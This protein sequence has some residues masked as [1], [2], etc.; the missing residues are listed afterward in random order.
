[1]TLLARRPSQSHS[2]LS[3]RATRGWDDHVRSQPLSLL[4][5]LRGRHQVMLPRS[6]QTAAPAAAHTRYSH[7]IVEMLEMVHDSSTM[8]IST[9][10]PAG[11]TTT[12][13]T[14]TDTPALA[15]STSASPSG[16]AT[17]TSPPT[18]PRRSTS[19]ATLNRTI[20]SSLRSMSDTALA[21]S[22]RDLPRAIGDAV[23][24]S[25]AYG[26]LYVGGGMPMCAHTGGATAVNM[27]WG[28]GS[29]MASRARSPSVVSLSSASDGN[30][31]G[32]GGRATTTGRRRSGGLREAMSR[33]RSASG[34]MES[35]RVNTHA[36]SAAAQ[37][38][39]SSLAVQG[40]EVSAD[41]RRAGD[42]DPDDDARPGVSTNGDDDVEEILD[43]LAV[44]MSR[45]STSSTHSSPRPSRRGPHLFRSNR[46]LRDAVASHEEV[47]PLPSSSSS[48][49]AAVS[50]TNPAATT[51]SQVSND[52]PGY[53][54]DLELPKYFRVSVVP[55]DEVRTPRTS[56]SREQSSTNAGREVTV[57]A[58]ITPTAAAAATSPQTSTGDHDHRRSL[59]AVERMGSPP[60]SYEIVGVAGSRGERILEGAAILERAQMAECV[61]AA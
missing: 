5:R 2:F 7:T 24:Q 27:S 12:D 15:T 44:P 4:D 60:P 18:Q 23:A 50:A 20:S 9:P 26:S 14:A 13:A 1:M 32:D 53:S 31:T 35:S 57:P 46:S 52:L 16:G 41:G 11:A 22:L 45:R 48:V 49:P 55:T 59:R 6:R 19:M 38:S 10:F 25:G 42:A 28:A 3:S 21:R 51:R 36:L 47:P 8:A 37:R 33:R 58:I 56:T 39:L 29:T 30:D 61:P 17:P 43:P 40:R 34:R 54:V